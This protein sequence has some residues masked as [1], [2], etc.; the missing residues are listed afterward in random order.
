M[1]ETIERRSFRCAG[2]PREIT[3]VIGLGFATA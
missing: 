1:R 3:V 2:V